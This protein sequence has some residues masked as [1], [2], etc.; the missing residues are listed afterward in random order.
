MNFTAAP[1]PPLPVITITPL[2]GGD[3]PLGFGNPLAIQT[4]KLVAPAIVLL[5]IL[6][7]LSV[8]SAFASAWLGVALFRRRTG[9]PL[10]PSN[11]ARLGWVIGAINFVVSLILLTLEFVTIQKD[12]LIKAMTKFSPELEPVLRDPVNLAMLM[13]AV[14][15]FMFFYF[16]GTGIAGGALAA[17]VSGNS[18]RSAV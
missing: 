16:V 18:S 14:V 10:T 1:P 5:S 6:P 13:G 3:Q 17:K 11:G 15:V 9:K 2:P 8:L 4:A 7:F 12:E